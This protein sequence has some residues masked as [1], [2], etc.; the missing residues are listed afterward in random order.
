MVDKKQ[1]ELSALLEVTQ[2]INANMAEEALYKI[3]YFTCISNLKF[4]RLGLIINEGEFVC[5]VTHGLEVNSGTIESLQTLDLS[6]KIIALVG[7][8]GIKEC[9]KIDFVIPVTHK[10]KCLAIVLIGESDHGEKHDSRDFSFVQ[11]LANVIMVAIENKRLARE[12]LKREALRKEMEIAQNV[13]SLLFPQKLPNNEHYELFSSYLPHTSV[14][15]DYYDCIKLT[16]GKVLFCIADVSGKGVPA[17]IL[18]SNFQA[19]LRTLARKTE[20]LKDIIFELNHLLIA[21]SGGAHFVTFFVGIYDANSR[22]LEYVNAGHNPP[23]LVNTNV[24]EA[25]ELKHGTVMLGAFDQL[26]FLNVGEEFIAPGSLL[27]CYTDGITETQNNDSEEFGEERTEKL[28]L[29][30]A[31]SDLS[32]LHQQLIIALDTFKQDRDYGDDLTLLSCR[33]F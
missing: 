24:P 32:E 13:Q 6:Q 19:A 12:T 23:F 20:D 25:K 15:G 30:Y 8:N 10:Q 14:G 16:E 5:K 1:L 9:E 17:A 18:M 7:L 11:T 33:I 27:F 2:A 4:Q 31:K 26:P 22:M 21:N 3:F 28:V 29:E